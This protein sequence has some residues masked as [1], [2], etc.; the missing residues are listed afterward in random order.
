[1]G[2]ECPEGPVFPF[3]DFLF[4]KYWISQSLANIPK[5]KY[6]GN[7]NKGK[8]NGAGLAWKSQSHCFADEFVITHAHSFGSD[9]Q[10]DFSSGNCST[11][12]SIIIKLENWLIVLTEIY[13]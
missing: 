3:Y 10:H 12:S 13:K 4:L 9:T 1:M 2:G 8:G 6:T 5:E 7:K 11:M